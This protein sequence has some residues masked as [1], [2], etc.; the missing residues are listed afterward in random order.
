MR[1]T[2]KKSRLTFSLVEGLHAYS[3]DRHWAY[4]TVSL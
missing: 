2:A 1:K 4:L 3:E